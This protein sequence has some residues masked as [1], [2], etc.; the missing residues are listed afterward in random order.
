MPIL[1]IASKGS[2]GLEWNGKGVGNDVFFAVFAVINKL[3]FPL[4]QRE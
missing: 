3:L 2:N 4:L 1:T